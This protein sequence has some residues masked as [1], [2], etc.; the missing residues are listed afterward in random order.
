MT[1]IS[2]GVA[3]ITAVPFNLPRMEVG[4]NYIF[5]SPYV[6]IVCIYIV[7]LSA[8]KS[9]R[10]QCEGAKGGIVPTYTV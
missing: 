9:S 7:D 3:K 6:L 1:K 10:K 5:L 8:V 2:V 4:L